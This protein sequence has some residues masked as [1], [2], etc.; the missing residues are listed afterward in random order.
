MANGSHH[1]LPPSSFGVNQ[2][3]FPINSK[4]V[5]LNSE[6]SRVSNGT[7]THTHSA[8]SSIF[9]IYYLIRLLMYASF[10]KWLIIRSQAKMTYRHGCGVCNRTTLAT[11][12][13]RVHMRKFGGGDGGGDEGGGGG[14]GKMCARC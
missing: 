5:V 2:F 10:Q 3:C 13:S 14:G 1:P 4:N 9:Q 11:L 8:L 12:L 7:H 6:C